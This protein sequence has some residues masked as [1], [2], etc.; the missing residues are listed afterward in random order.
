MLLSTLDEDNQMAKQKIT[1]PVGSEAKIEKNRYSASG[2]SINHSRHGASVYFESG[3]DELI[4]TL[5]HYRDKYK[6]EYE[7]MRIDSAR[8]CGC[9]SSDCS[10]SPSYFVVGTRL[11]TD[12]EE[13]FRLRKE[14]A[15]KA[16][17][18]ENERR[19]YA[20]L[21]AKFDSK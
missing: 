3:L 8:D 20:A 2:E 13:A 7:N 18:E 4:D 5:V 1:V 10:C 14:A 9:Y 11:E 12:V 19:Q 16:R 6:N 15:E 21:K 17:S